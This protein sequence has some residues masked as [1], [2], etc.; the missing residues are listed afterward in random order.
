[1][2]L[3]FVAAAVAA[4][5]GPLLQPSGEEGGMS[6][7]PQAGSATFRSSANL[8]IL[9]DTERLRQADWRPK[10]LLWFSDLCSAAAPPTP[11]VL[12]LK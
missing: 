5:A 7:R 1:M 11:D 6:Q 8:Q 3:A 10:Q 12:R 9:T 4:G 2:L